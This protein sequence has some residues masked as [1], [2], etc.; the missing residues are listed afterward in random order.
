[1]DLCLS[2]QEH[3][4]RRHITNRT[5]QAHVVVTIDVAL[6]QTPGIFQGERGKGPD[7]LAFQ[8]LVPALQFAIGLSIQMRRIATLRID[9]SE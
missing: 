5:V 8:R 3:I 9:V 1:M 6:N 7:T 4:V 2:T